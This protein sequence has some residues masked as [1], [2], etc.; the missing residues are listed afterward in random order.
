MK[1]HYY[2]TY[3]T[4]ILASLSLFAFSSVEASVLKNEFILQTT[5]NFKDSKWP[6]PELIN[7]SGSFHVSFK[8]YKVTPSDIATKLA[9]WLKLEEKHS[10]IKVS[11]Q[12]DALGI[13]HSVYQQYYN[14]MEIEGKKVL[15]HSKD[16]RILSINGQV[17]NI[18]KI[19]TTPRIGEK[20]AIE[21]A[22]A[23]FKVNEAKTYTPQL[24]I[25]S[26]D[27]EEKSNHK[28]IYLIRIDAFKPF[29]MKNVWVDA[30]EGL[31][32]NA[33][34][35]VAHADVNG[36]G[37]TIYYG[38]QDIIVD[39]FEEGYRLRDQSRN[40]NTYDASLVDIA[41]DYEI[42]DYI[43]TNQQDIV[44]DS[45][46]FPLNP[47]IDA[48]W[49]MEKTYD[50][51]KDT[52]N[53][54]SYDNNN[55][56]IENYINPIAF[57]DFFPDTG[58]PNNAVAMPAPYNFMAF[59]IGDNT[60]M[61]PLVKIDV[62]GHEFT[63]MVVSNNGNGGLKYQGESG[64]LNES[65]ADIFGASIEHYALGE[66][67][68]WLIAEDILLNDVKNYFRNMGDPKD[69][70][71]PDTYKG[72]YWASTY[73]GSRD[74][75]GVHTNSGVQ[76]YWFYLLVEGGIGTND[77]GNEYNVEGI[78]REKAEWIAYHNLMNYLL[79]D[80]E[81]IDAYNGSLQAAEDRFGEDSLEYNSVKEAW[82]AVGIGEKDEVMGI[83]DL[84]IGKQIKIYPNPTKNGILRINTAFTNPIK[85]EL[86]NLLGQKISTFTA[87]YGE[88]ILS[89]DHLSTGVYMLR[90]SIEGKSYTE[91]I[92]IS[93]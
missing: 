53:R 60:R 22:K 30:Q 78:G 13:T 27:T 7:Q 6:Q 50:Y 16:N 33:V 12:K 8:G 1:Q 47:A 58:F 15:I 35:L 43:Y 85:M 61:S 44:H 9:D 5:N 89:V 42:W 4:V 24:T 10:F 38:Q 54:L 90:F 91:K 51:Y 81:Y 63:H 68:N 82:Y 41:F 32:I 29:L 80:S 11:E 57:V 45:P 75:G 19:N 70:M 74:S 86:F 17:L 48:H 28:L 87:S 14:Q 62:A 73:I 52:F 69:K 92:I 46:I 31:V 49:G 67:A 93:K 26:L 71:H 84:E 59:G 77:K 56:I 79:P 40:I 88:N 39:Q 18:Q 23:H 72:R 83:A 25:V 37:Q 76:N 64:A 20:E 2:P 65:F 36:S 66:Q 34:D 3:K 21:I 55:S